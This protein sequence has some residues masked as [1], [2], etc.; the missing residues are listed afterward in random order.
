MVRK[1]KLLTEPMQAQ[2][3]PHISVLNDKGKTGNLRQNLSKN[4]SQWDQ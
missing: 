2:S 1:L 3:N 4:L